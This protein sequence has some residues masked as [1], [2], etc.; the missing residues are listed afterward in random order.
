MSY[1]TIAIG[2][3]IVVVLVTFAILLAETNMSV[4]SFNAV[5]A[6]AA[7][8]VVIVGVAWFKKTAKT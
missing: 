1:R 6:I 3:A 8:T 7:V 4:Q 5:G 2:G